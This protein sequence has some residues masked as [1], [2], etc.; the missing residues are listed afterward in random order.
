MP[1][2]EIEDSFDVHAHRDGLKLRNQS[3]DTMRLENR[4]GYGCPACNQ[5]FHELLIVERPEIS[6][7]SA[8]NGPICLVRTVDQILVL[9]HE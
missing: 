1:A 9:T 4:A 7:T 8:P 3:R 5:P 6:F 2:L